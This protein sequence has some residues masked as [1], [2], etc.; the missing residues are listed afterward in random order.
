MLNCKGIDTFTTVSS[1]TITAIL[2]CAVVSC[3]R[4]GYWAKYL[5]LAF[6]R[7]VRVSAGPSYVTH[8][9]T[10][11]I[12]IVA[13]LPKSVP[14]IN[15]NMTWYELSEYRTVPIFR[16][17]DI[18]TFE[19]YC[20]NIGPYLYSDSPMFRHVGISVHFCRN[21]GTYLSEYRYVGIA[22]RRNSGTAPSLLVP[23]HKRP[24]TT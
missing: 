11:Q 9:H 24:H 13:I 14:E 18:P 6:V 2:C 22:V 7:F 20:R 3:P 8:T 4:G 19:H 21:S 5:P 1:H 16:Q 15:M 23:I 10:L 12:S 17:T